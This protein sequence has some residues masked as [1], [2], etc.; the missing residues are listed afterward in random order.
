MTPA[1]AQSAPFDRS[2]V[3]QAARDLAAKPFKAPDSKLPDNLKD[4]DYD[5]YRAIRRMLAVRHGR[6]VV[7]STPFG[8]RGWFYDEWQG[9]GPFKK[10]RV[11]WHD[12]PRITA[13]FIAEEE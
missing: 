8:Q 3:R 12:C 11:T 6:L 1:N 10:V 5:R 2:V 4:L 9:S 13:D 7:L